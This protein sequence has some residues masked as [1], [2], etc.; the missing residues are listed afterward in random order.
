MPMPKPKKPSDLC[1]GSN[2]GANQEGK[3]PKT[4]EVKVFKGEKIFP[5]ISTMLVDLAQKRTQDP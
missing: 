3:T 5:D 2:G 1:I 4:L